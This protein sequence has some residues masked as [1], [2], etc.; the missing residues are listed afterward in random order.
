MSKRSFPIHL[1]LLL[2]FENQR[3]NVFRLW[4]ATFLLLT[5]QFS[6]NWVKSC[7][8]SLIYIFWIEFQPTENNTESKA[9][10]NSTPALLNETPPRFYVDVIY[11]KSNQIKSLD[12]IDESNEMNSS[13]W[14]V[15]EGIDNRRKHWWPWRTHQS[16]RRKAVRSWQF[17]QQYW[18]DW[19]MPTTL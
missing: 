1:F 10:H 6:T 9:H 19:W 17:W 16:S 2:F 15:L 3:R 12:P 14:G 5:R 13:V 4:Q 7:F 8:P 11:L 18:S